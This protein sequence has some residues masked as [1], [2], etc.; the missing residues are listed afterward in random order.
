MGGLVMGYQCNAMTGVVVGVRAM[1]RS[2]HCEQHDK[3]CRNARATFV[4]STEH[5]NNHGTDQ[6]EPCQV[7]VFLM[8]V[9]LTT[10]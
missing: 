9:P 7:G 2:D 10:S 1:R 5:R 3:C 8:S 6:L 4:D